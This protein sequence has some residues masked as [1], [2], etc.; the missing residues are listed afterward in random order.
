MPQLLVQPSFSPNL[1]TKYLGLGAGSFGSVVHGFMEWDTALP[2]YSGLA[3]VQ[4]QFNP[5]TLAIGYYNQ[6][7]NQT[8][9]DFIFSDPANT[10]PVYTYLQQSVS[11]AL[12]YDR[13]Y[14][15]WGSYNSAGLPSRVA[16]PDQPGDVNDPGAAGVGV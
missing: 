11:F 1:G 14:E 3:Q 8:V 5:S 6:T 9:Q 4:F 7:N 16:F 13:T 2:G 15:L 12:L 10:A